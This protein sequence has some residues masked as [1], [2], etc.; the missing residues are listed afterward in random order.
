MTWKAAFAYKF[1]TELVV[2]VGLLFSAGVWSLMSLDT[3]DTHAQ[4]I[5]MIPFMY[6]YEY[7]EPSEFDFCGH[8]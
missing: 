6:I 2:T 3:H 8:I 7:M 4:A 5:H 1:S